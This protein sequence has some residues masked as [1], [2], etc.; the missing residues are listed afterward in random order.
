MGKGKRLS[1]LV[2]AIICSIST[3]IILLVLFYFFKINIKA[4]LNNS[5]AQIALGK[6]YLTSNSQNLDSLN[7]AKYWFKKADKNNNPLGGFY[8]GKMFYD[9]VGGSQDK[10]QALLYFI[11]SA[12]KGCLESEFNAGLMLLNGD[13]V[14]GRVDLAIPI[15]EDVANH[16]YDPACRALGLYYFKG[17]SNQGPDFSKSLLWFEKSVNT[18]P[19]FSSSYY[20]LWKIYSDKSSNFYNAEKAIRFRSIMVEEARKGASKGDLDAIQTLKELNH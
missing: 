4:R 11:D 2:M 18:S 14:E 3:L 5:N 1:S 12:K 20:Y 6:Q 17:G 7:K 8:L 16:G 10:Q 9:G 19:G 13:G 15:L